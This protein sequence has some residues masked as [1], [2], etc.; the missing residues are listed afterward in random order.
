MRRQRP[1]PDTFWP[2]PFAVPGRFR[3][4]LPIEIKKTFRTP[5]TSQWDRDSFTGQPFLTLSW[6][7]AALE[8]EMNPLTCAP[9]IRGIWMAVN[10]GRILNPDYSR[11]V[12]EASIL[13]ALRW[14][15][16]PEIKY[17]TV[18]PFTAENP[19]V[20]LAGLPITLDFIQNRGIPT[21]GIGTLADN[22]IPAAYAAAL[23]QAL[24][25]RINALP[26]IPGELVKSGEE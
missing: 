13:R 22:T 24:G 10:C 11:T 4:P 21:G 19:T 9:E 26:V 5:K 1:R 3:T 23:S 17:G 6:A 7:A 25:R 20:P 8:V 12:L 18:G 14:C 2:G 15:T 16:E